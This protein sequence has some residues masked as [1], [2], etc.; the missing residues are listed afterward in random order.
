MRFFTIAL[1]PVFAIIFSQLQPDLNDESQAFWYYC[2]NNQSKAIMQRLAIL[3]ICTSSLTINAQEN[4]DSVRIEAVQVAE[5]LYFLKGSGG[6]IG[7]F[8]GQEGTLMVDDQYAPLSNKI[9]G[10]IKTLSPHDIRFLINTHLHGDHSGGNENFKKMGVTIVAHDM[11]RDRMSKEKINEDKT[12][13]PPRAED[14]WPVIS[15]SDKLNFYLNSE[16]IELLHVSPA[17]TDGDVVVHFKKA[18]VFHMGDLFVTYGYPY[19]DYGNGGSIN[20]FIASLD[21]FLS[22]MDDKTKVIPGHGEL[23]SKA[24][25]KKFRDRLTEFRDEVAAALK[26][27]RKLEDIATLPIATKYDAEWG[28]GFLKGKDF[29]L[30]IAEDLKK[31]QA[32]KK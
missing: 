11:V 8:I 16:D 32:L 13:T 6:N 15:F 4:F 18:N 26:K 27:G 28:S 19:I 3:L 7:V 9:N 12:T 20:G 23:C 31:T 5:N 17:H 14:A 22:L 30:Q 21:T 10:A 2:K 1:N 24:D 25:V 29:V